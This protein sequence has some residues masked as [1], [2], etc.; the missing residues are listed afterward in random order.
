[1]PKKKKGLEGPNGYPESWDFDVDITLKDP[2]QKM[3]VWK[4]EQVGEKRIGKLMAVTNTKYN[5]ILRLAT[6]SGT[7]NVPV[8]TH[9]ADI[10]FGQY[11][12]RKFL[13][14]FTGKA[15]RNCRLFRVVLLKG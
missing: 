1:M 14:E 15:G 2:S 9:L 6:A 3:S 10:D 8:S 5:P 7:E 12:G 13:F 4:P 11:I